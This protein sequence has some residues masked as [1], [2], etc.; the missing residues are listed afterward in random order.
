M[1]ISDEFV[2]FKIFPNLGYLNSEFQIIIFDKKI[3][4][5]EIF[6]EDRIYKEINVNSNTSITLREFNKAGKYKASCKINEMIFELEFEIQ[7]SIR[8]GDSILKK[9]FAFEDVPYSIYLM[10]DRMYIYNELNKNIYNENNI[11]PDE[12]IQVNKDYLL[13]KT[14]F[15]ASS[16]E[17]TNY[18]IYSLKSFKITWELVGNYKEINFMPNQN[19]L[20]IDDF[21]EK[22]IYAFDLNK[23]INNIPLCLFNSNYEKYYFNDKNNEFYIE[24]PNK[25]KI[26]DVLSNQK[27]EILKTDNAALDYYGNYYLF[28]NNIMTIYKSESNYL[29]KIEVNEIIRPKFENIDFFYS[30][31]TFHINENSNID[32]LINK[33]TPINN[34]SES[35]YRHNLEITDYVKTEDYIYQFFPIGE[36]GFFI[37]KNKNKTLKG[38]NYSKL[39]GIWTGTPEYYSYENQYL[40]LYSPIEPN[41][42]LKSDKNLKLKYYT[43]KGIVIDYFTHCIFYGSNRTQ[44]Q[45]NVHIKKYLHSKEKDYLI[46]SYSVNSYTEEYNV[47]DLNNILNKDNKPEFFLTKIKILNYDELEQ[48][49]YF[50]YTKLNDENIYSLKAFEIVSGNN[51]DITN[52]K[53]RNFKTKKYTD[54]KFFKNYFMIDNDSYFNIDNLEMRDGII[55]DIS[56]VTATLN[57]IISRRGDK[58]YLNLYNKNLSKYDLHE[59][60]LKSKFIIESYLAPNGNYLIL[61]EEYGKY[62]YYDLETETTTEF[63]SGKFVAFT[64]EGN[65]IYNEN[66]TRNTVVIDPLTLKIITPSNYHYYRYNSPDR[67]LFAPLS[68]IVKYYDN[69]KNDFVQKEDLIEL[70]NLLNYPDK[71]TDE[72]SNIINENR[73]KYFNENIEYFKNEN[74]KSPKEIQV[75]S[76]IKQ[77]KFLEIGVV[78]CDVK[79]LLE[80]PADL[81][82]LN[83]VSFSFNSNYIACVGATS[84]KGF[85]TFCK[86][87]FDKFKNIL[88]IEDAVTTKFQNAIWVCG[89]SRNNWLAFYDSAP[90]TYMLKTIDTLLL[91]QIDYTKLENKHNFLCFSNSGNLMALSE[92]GYNAISRNGSGHQPSTNLH[93]LETDSRKILT[94]FNEHGDEIKGTKTSNLSFVAFSKDEKRIMS[95]S[96]DGVVIVRNINFDHEETSK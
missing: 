69:I 12:I 28:I 95:L 62:L 22:N 86:Y 94:S 31:F 53:L 2:P 83:Y 9:C 75:N 84:S 96:K 34:Y 6:I 87:N 77:K 65:V 72:E 16:E 36:I 70:N 24:T 71:I 91:D 42:L 64:N 52:N 93:I 21:E 19:I 51:I 18:A 41:K 79:G 58:I 29:N 7:N 13:F 35:K 73:V 78:D 30:G 61:Q 45:I 40:F 20:W 50:W 74:I 55:G 57:K 59:I 85:I 32:A 81:T 56:N 46:T 5:I 43:N 3:D 8:I 33:F 37:R 67:N 92:Q 27:Y 89:F 10:K 76:I 44:T 4:K 17:I 66:K 11:S 63:F 90:Y 60:T 49:K 14:K 68:A 38:I 80:L 25:I 88:I 15:N 26:I 82:F 1:E 48:A 39:N 54:F 47:L 23:I